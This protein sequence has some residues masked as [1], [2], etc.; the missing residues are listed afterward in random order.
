[1]Q[2]QFKKCSFSDL[3]ILIDISKKTFKDAFEKDNNP[4]DFKIYVNAAFEKKNILNQL[5]NK[6]TSFYFVFKDEQL[7]GYMKLN[8]NEAQ[9][10]IKSDDSIELERI[11][12]LQEFQGQQIGRRMVAKA[13]TMARYQKKKYIWLGVWEKNT[14]AIRFYE[15]Q[16]FVKFNTHPYYI[17]KDKQT[18]W[19]MRYDL[20]NAQEDYKTH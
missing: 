10:D 1:M 12:V 2:L 14:E 16:G 7:V 3:V 4:S 8:V 11:Y 9:T 17:G 5:E 19:L 15:K 20:T 6:N 13:I 18:D